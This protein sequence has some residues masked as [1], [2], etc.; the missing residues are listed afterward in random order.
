MV[1]RAENGNGRSLSEIQNILRTLGRADEKQ[2]FQKH[3]PITCPDS[4]C[5]AKDMDIEITQISDCVIISSEIS[6]AAIVNLIAHCWGSA[7]MLLRSGVMVRGYVTRGLIH[8]N[9]NE[10]IG[11]GYQKAFEGEATVTA[12]KRTADE[13]GT[14]FIE[15]DPAVCDYVRDC[16]DPCVREMFSRFVRSDGTATAIFPFQRLAH[17]FIIGDY[18]GR[19]F[20]PQKEKQSNSNVRKLLGDFRIAVLQFV[21]QG[22]P[23]ALAK[24]AHYVAAL[25]AQLAIC[26]RTDEFL[27]QL[28][29]PLLPQKPGV[30]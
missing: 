1:A 15:I 29:K 10:L 21:D 23:K 4:Q 14:P 3:G 26:D 28:T 11:T 7:L 22:N 24:A 16:T 18:A 25:D 5:L 9:G 8:H 27:D 13:R 19:K 17:S 2:K 6:P 12:F 30:R 20:D